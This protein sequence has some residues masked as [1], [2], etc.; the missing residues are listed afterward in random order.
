[1]KKGFWNKQLLLA[2]LL[3]Q[4]VIALPAFANTPAGQVIFA[5]GPNEVS[6]VGNEQV[7]SKGSRVMKSPP[8]RGHAFN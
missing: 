1:V 2:G 7:L 5:S 3:F 6:G 4:A 8:A